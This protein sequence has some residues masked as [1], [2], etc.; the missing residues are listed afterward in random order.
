[1][2]FSFGITELKLCHFK[3]IH[4]KSISPLIHDRKLFSLLFRN[5]KKVHFSHSHSG[6]LECT[7]G[8]CRSGRGNEEEFSLSTKEE[9]TVFL[10][11]PIILPRL[12]FHFS[13]SL[14]LESGRIV[15][16]KILM[17]AAGYTGK[18]VTKVILLASCF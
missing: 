12:L 10:Y 5:L 2:R 15:E 4:S 14:L 3:Y 1:M 13:L 17:N 7:T 11:A 16:K 8:S 18:F 9:K 6:M